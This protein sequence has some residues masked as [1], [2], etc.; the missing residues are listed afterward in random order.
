MY[1]NMASKQKLVIHNVI[2]EQIK[3]IEICKTIGV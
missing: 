3:V 2:D 1:L